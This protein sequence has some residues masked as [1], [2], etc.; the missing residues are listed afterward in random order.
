MKNIQEGTPAPDTGSLGT[1]SLVIGEGRNSVQLVKRVVD[2]VTLYVER[3]FDSTAAESKA[4][5]SQ[6]ANVF[7]QIWRWATK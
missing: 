7:S 6:S 4:K 2:G 5:P 3:D 1:G